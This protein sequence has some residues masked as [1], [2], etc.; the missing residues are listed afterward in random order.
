MS[1]I[2][3]RADNNNEPLVLDDGAELESGIVL[4]SG[5]ATLVAGAVLAESPPTSGTYIHCDVALLTSGAAYPKLVLAEDVLTSSGQ[6]TVSA[7]SMA[8]LTESKLSFGGS[9]DL[10]SRIEIV[11]N[12]YNLS[13]R[14]A[15]RQ[16]GLRVASDISLTG[17][18]NPVI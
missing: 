8:L 1:S 6:T 9:T 2:Q 5:H 10:D 14:D 16:M 17:F 7:Y 3:T 18:E 12:N 15:M 4:A 11:A 13:M